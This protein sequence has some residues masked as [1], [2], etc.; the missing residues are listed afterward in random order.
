MEEKAIRTDREEKEDSVFLLGSIRHTK[1]KNNDEKK[2]SK[3]ETCVI[4]RL[5]Q[6]KEVRQGRD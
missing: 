3:S 2:Y 1:Q 5:K 4:I 6:Q